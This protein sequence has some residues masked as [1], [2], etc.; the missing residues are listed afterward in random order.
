VPLDATPPLV[1]LTDLAAAAALLDI[2]PRARTIPEPPAPDLGLDPRAAFAER[3]RQAEQRSAARRGWAERLLADKSEI[4]LA[5]HGTRWPHAARLLADVMALSRDPTVPLAA[6]IGDPPLIE[7][8][9]EV[10][11]RHPLRLR[12]IPTAPPPTAVDAAVEAGEDGNATRE[13]DS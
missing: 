9:A 2:A 12:R 10:V 4:D 3:Q 8:G 1:H 13:M 7:P 5:D 6:D 11:V